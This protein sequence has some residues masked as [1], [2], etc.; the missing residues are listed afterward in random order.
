MK[1]TG[2]I[3][4]KDWIKRVKKRKY[5]VTNVLPLFLLGSKGL[6][7]TEESMNDSK[8]VDDHGKLKYDKIKYDLTE[9]FDHTPVFDEAPVSKWF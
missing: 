9:L 7:D 8:F 5:E 2:T 6:N 4:S 1:S 3:K